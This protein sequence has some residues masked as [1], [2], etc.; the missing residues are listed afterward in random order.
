MNKSKIVV[1]VLVLLLLPIFTTTSVVGDKSVGALD[2]GITL[3]VGGIGPGN[4]TKIQD[5]IDNASDGDT[6]FVYNGTYYENIII[7]EN[8]NLVGEDKDTTIIDGC[9]SNKAV[10]ICA[11]NVW[12][13]GFTVQNTTRYKDIWMSSGIEIYQSDF[14]SIKNNIFLNNYNSVSMINSTGNIFRNNIMFNC[15]ISIYG[16]SFSY[17]I[18]DIDTSNIANG[19]P[20]Y[21]YRDSAGLTPPSNAGE[22]ILVNCS[23]FNITNLNIDNDSI[24]IQICYS[25]NNIVENNSFFNNAEGIFLFQS[26]FNII[27]N[28]TCYGNDFDGIFLYFSNYNTVQNNTCSNNIGGIVLYDSENNKILRNTVKNNHPLSFL[29]YNSNKN[30]IICNNV[31]DSPNGGHALLDRRSFFNNWDRNYWNK[32][33]GLK[34]KL[35]RSFPKIIIGFIEI[36]DKPYKPIPYFAFDL[37]PAGKPYDI[38]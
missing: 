25:H 24:S 21:Y 22:L 29:I 1:A 28:N 20:I 18:Q 12:I 31:I 3:Y 34:F 38:M 19:K 9:G 33:V 17:Y 23:D 8:I 7:N 11:N 26:N 5:A 32:W 2:G 27:R 6:V 15:S 10:K 37:H 30:D 35:F 14:V 13:S 4:Y 36:I 16:Y